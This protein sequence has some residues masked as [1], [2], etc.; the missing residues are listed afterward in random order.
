MRMRGSGCDW[1]GHVPAGRPGRP[2]GCERGWRM[3]RRD[4]HEDA[5]KR[6]CHATHDDERHTLPHVAVAAWA[7]AQLGVGV[8]S[9]AEGASWW[10]AACQT[11]KG[12]ADVRLEIE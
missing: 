8:G 2:K 12:R 4:E 11:Q 7:R 3:M 1:R 5:R 10:C 9:A 6:E